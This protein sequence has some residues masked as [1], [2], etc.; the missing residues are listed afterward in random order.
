[1]I[2]ELYTLDAL[3]QLVTQNPDAWRPMVFTCGCFDLIHAGHVRY[4][5][6]AKLLGR[7]LVV[8]LNTDASVRALKPQKL[9]NLTRPIT[10]EMQR[11]E[12]I[13]G[14]KPVDAVVMFAE[15]TATSVIQALQPDIY[16]KGGDYRVETLPE[17]PAVLAYGGKIELIAIELPTSTT[18][19]VKKIA[20][21]I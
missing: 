17:A 15:L 3:C 14:L 5:R 16:A 8:G 2:P 7:S 12:V 6:S 9:G 20:E 10:P 19:I 21:A 4:L 11:A 13:A 1:M 18:G